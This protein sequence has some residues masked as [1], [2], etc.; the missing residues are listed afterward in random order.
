MQVCVKQEFVLL[1]GRGV[2]AKT[3]GGKKGIAR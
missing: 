1:A 3:G 2:R